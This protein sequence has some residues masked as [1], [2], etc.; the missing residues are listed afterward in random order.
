MKDTKN[1]NSNFYVI[2]FDVLFIMI[3]CFATLL[4]TMF[5]NGAVIVGSSSSGNMEYGFSMLTFAITMCGLG[6]YLLY[7]LLQSNKQL[8]YMIKEIYG[9]KNN[10]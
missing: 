6:I 3:L 2:V 7:I 10:N 5:V 8:T 9:H 4:T 1:R